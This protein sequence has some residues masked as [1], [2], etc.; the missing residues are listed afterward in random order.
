MKKIISYLICFVCVFVFLLMPSSNNT[1][2]HSEEV[3]IN[4]DNNVSIDFCTLIVSDNIYIKYYVKSTNE[5]LKLLVF[6]DYHKPFIKGNEIFVLSRD[7]I[8]EVDN[9]M[10][11]T[12]TFRGLSLKNA[13]DYY[14]AV[15]YDA[16]TNTYGKVNKYSVIQYCY[17]M[18]GKTKEIVNEN[19]ELEELLTNILNVC[20]SAQKYFN[21]KKDKLA[22]EEFYQIKVVNGLLPDGFAKGLFHY[23]DTVNISS[24]NDTVCFIDEN[25]EVLGIGDSFDYHLENSNKVITA[26]SDPDYELSSLVDAYLE[27]NHLLDSNNT[28]LSLDTIFP[29]TNNGIVYTYTTNNP[30][31]YIDEFG[32][33]DVISFD[34]PSFSIVNLNISVGAYS[35]NTE[36]Y[37][38]VPS[39]SLEQ[40]ELYKVFNLGDNK[41]VDIKHDDGTKINEDTLNDLSTLGLSL[42]NCNSVYYGAC[43]L[44]GNSCLKIG[45]SSLAGSFIINVPSYVSKVKLFVAKYKS[46]T[47]KLSIN[48]I[49]YNLTKNS[50]DGEY[51]EIIIDTSSTKVIDFSSQVDSSKYRCMIN[52]IEYYSYEYSAYDQIDEAIT[53]VDIPKVVNSGYALTTSYGDVEISYTCNSNYITSLTNTTN[54]EVYARIVATISNNIASKNRIYNVTILPSNNSTSTTNNIY[55]I[56]N[57]E[58]YGTY[59]YQDSDDLKLQLRELITTTHTYYTTYDDIKTM[60]V[61]TDTDPNNPN[62]IILLYTRKSVPG[63]WD[64]GRTWNREHVWCQS[65][66]WF[67]TSEAGSDLHHLRPA[68]QSVNSTRNN[69]LYGEVTNGKICYE[70]SGDSNTLYAGE[71]KDNYFEP[72]DE[73]KGD[74][75]RIIFYLMLRYTESDSYTFESI[76][77][78]YEMFKRWNEIDPVD[79]LEVYRNNAVE[80][81]QGNRNPFIDDPTLNILIWG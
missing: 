40:E 79:E 9:T 48:G 15:G 2:V 49:T 67:T 59:E 41:I 52:T 31:T 24:T 32:N 69:Q 6:N 72:R 16:T 81:I 8:E 39:S 35:I 36:F 77:Q 60:T 78:S 38:N 65:L 62:N 54:E 70:V 17:N 29:Y 71:Y 18:L 66:S 25:N 10:Y 3:N 76:G 27:F 43:D 7:S 61:L 74:I 50:D 4:I 42:E 33:L 73:V 51:D 13:S 20:S 75:A 14:Y 56:D 1:I 5:D 46:N 68:D 37:I 80:E 58:Y 64:G 47:T 44:L 30:Q 12:F 21:Y 11:S 19:I 23:L 53:L 28:L 57:N 63:N 26:I 55:T 45:T 22:N 34:E